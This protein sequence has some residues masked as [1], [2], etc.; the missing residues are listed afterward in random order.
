PAVATRVGHF[1]ETIKDGFNGYMAEPKNIADMVRAMNAM[2]EKPIPRENV[3]EATKE[4]SWAN[5]AKAVL[6]G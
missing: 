4:M 6:K 3:V 1:P 2:I 5:Y